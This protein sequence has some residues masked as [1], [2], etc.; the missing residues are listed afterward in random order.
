MRP[1]ILLVAGAPLALGLVAAVR[2]ATPESAAA[3][4]AAKNYAAALREYEELVGAS[5]R[6]ATL[7]MRLGTTLH[8]LGRPAD[9]LA[10]FQGAQ[11]LGFPASEVLFW[12]ARSEAR[13]GRREAALATVTKAAAQG[14]SRP[15]ALETEDDLAGLR[16][17]PAFAAAVA[18]ADRNGR[19]CAFLPEARGFD[20]WVGEWQVTQ[21]TSGATAGESRIEK[22][23]NDCVILENWTG[24]NGYS[25][26]SF[27]FWDVT[28][29][30][31]QQTWVDSVGGLTEYVGE[32]R[33]GRLHFTAD[34][35]TPGQERPTKL[36]MTFTLR[37][38]GSVR[39]LGESSTDDGRTFTVSYDL[40][41]R[42][43]AP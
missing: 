34:Q 9:A 15:A 14:F 19:P 6:D 41:Y 10:H 25:G 1:I 39:Q 43:K 13:L 11:K 8:E 33:E 12:T 26:K 42:R 20:F 38:D 29:K 18:A 21:A 23:L 2:A 5:P 35:A 40:I 3:L 22:I 17:D 32:L 7:R 30:R 16:A 27:N 37:P 36:K 28:K 31:W 24:Q 4:Y